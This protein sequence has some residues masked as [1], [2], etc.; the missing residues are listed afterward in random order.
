[1]LGSDISSFRRMVLAL[2]AL[3]FL[4]L[5]FNSISSER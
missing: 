1:M 2:V 4:G 3:L 5:A